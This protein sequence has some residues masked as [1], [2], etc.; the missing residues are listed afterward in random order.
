MEKEN[1]LISACLLGVNCKYSGG[2]NYKKQ[3]ELLKEKYNLIPICPE[4][5]GGLETPREPSEIV[6]SKVINKK[7]IDVTPQFKKGAEETL[8]L[9]KFYNV[10]LAILK[11]KSPSCGF[12]E[13]YDGTF[14]GKLKTG[15]GITAELLFENGIKIIGESNIEM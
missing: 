13:I 11:E 15:N 1:V 2:N 9:V 7:G 5:Y 4:I 12:K 3:V 8:K 6:D 14:S 10:K